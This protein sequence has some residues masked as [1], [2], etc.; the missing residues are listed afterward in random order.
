MLRLVSPQYGLP[1]HTAKK[2]APYHAFT[3][4]GHISYI[5]LDGDEVE[6]IKHGQSI[7]KVGFCDNHIVILIY[8]NAIVA[9]GK[10]LQEKIIVK[11]VFL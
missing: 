8:N 7:K 1:S 10:I 4:A 5:E 9:V 6:K 3:N 11:K 2:E